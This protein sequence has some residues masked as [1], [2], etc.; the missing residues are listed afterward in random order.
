MERS[1]TMPALVV[2]AARGPCMHCTCEISCMHGKCAIFVQARQLG[3]IAHA[4]QL[5]YRAFMAAVRDCAC[6]ATVILCLHGNRDI[7]H[8]WHS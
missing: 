4:W 2:N 1:E 5:R 6:I 3:D 7:V 8:A